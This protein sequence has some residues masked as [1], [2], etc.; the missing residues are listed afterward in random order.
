MVLKTKAQVGGLAPKVAL[1]SVEYAAMQI[2]DAIVS[3]RFAP[4]TRLIESRLTDQLNVS[5]HPVREALKRLSREGFVE[6]RPNR[7]AIVAEINPENILEVYAI[8]S[9]LG[10]IALRALASKPELLTG[11]VIRDL[12]RL[13][14]NALRFA[15]EP[16]QNAS[17]NNHLE[18]QDAI[19]K[20]SQ[21]EKTARYFEELTAEVVRFNNL[22][23]MTYTDREKDA[24]ER[25]EA[26]AKAI[27][28]KDFVLAEQIWQHS[29]TLAAERFIERMGD[30]HA[31]APN[32]S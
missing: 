29:F 18:F 24:L 26:L 13:T 2:R 5:R 4:G 6:V 30:D 16:D 19:V 28:D 11:S 1:D 20:A 7:G 9:A 10:T 31:K 22:L 3:G 25:I 12:E 21:L 17:I 8:R 15:K 23:S 32:A 27:K 14:R